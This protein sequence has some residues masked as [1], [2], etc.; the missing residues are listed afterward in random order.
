[1]DYNENIQL[2]SRKNVNAVDIDKH[3]NLSLERKNSIFTDYN[4]KKFINA[5]D[6]FEEERENA[7]SYRIYGTINYLSL[8]NGIPED[9]SNISDFFIKRINPTNYRDFIECFD[10]YLLKPANSFEH[11]KDDLYYKY[12][13]IL[14]KPNDINIKKCGF[15]KN[16]FHEDVYYF[17]YDIEFNIKELTDGLG[18]PITELYLYIKYKPIDDEI[19]EYPDFTSEDPPFFLLENLT[20]NGDVGDVLT[21]VE[22]DLP[23]SSVIK[24]NKKN[25]IQEIKYSHLHIITTNEIEIDTETQDKL[26][27]IYNPFLK[28]K[29]KHLSN[30]LSTANRNS[31]SYEQINNIPYYAIDL[32]TNGNVIWREVLPDGEID[33]EINEGLDH[34]F[35]N[36]KK[37][38]FNNFTFECLSNLGQGVEE[39]ESVLPEPD[40]DDPT[41]KAFSEILFNEEK[42]I[43]I[44]PINNDL[45]KIGKKCQ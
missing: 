36:N 33:L 12:Y 44:N 18:F 31:T 26:Q 22:N 23:I 17:D 11:I 4:I 24:L 9:Y 45:N 28:I 6:V 1:M 16:I 27:F 40:E 20:I 14:A 32:D 39:G 41:Y 35:V 7:D 30:S 2:E 25:Y 34:P 3:I 19:L 43:S 29:I 13:E 15:E 10:I 5:S 37:Y 8:L 42:I 38:V 21:D